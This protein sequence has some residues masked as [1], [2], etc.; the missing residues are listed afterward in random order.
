MTVIHLRKGERRAALILHT[1]D[2]VTGRPISSTL[3]AYLYLMS[4]LCMLRGTHLQG[5]AAQLLIALVM[6]WIRIDLRWI[7]LAILLIPTAR[8]VACAWGSRRFEQKAFDTLEE[9]R[10]G[11]ASP[12]EERRCR[13]GRDR[14]EEKKWPADEGSQP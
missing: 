11:G 2:D 4:T 14:E 13:D 7:L 8:W 12:P 10:S 5:L 1:V 9:D 3:Q 6:A